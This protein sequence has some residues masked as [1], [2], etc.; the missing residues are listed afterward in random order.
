MASLI[1]QLAARPSIRMRSRFPATKPIG[2]MPIMAM[3]SRHPCRMVRI[4]TFLRPD[5][6]LRRDGSIR[7]AGL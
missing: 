3:S 2:T 1:T 4:S 5:P 6:T 7:R